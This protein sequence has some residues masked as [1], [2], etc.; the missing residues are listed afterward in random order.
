MKENKTY[1]EKPAPEGHRDEDGH[2][3]VL[4]N[5]HKHLYQCTGRELN[6][7]KILKSEKKISRQVGKAT[8]P[9]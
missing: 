7:L 5:T 9:A 4:I 6:A 2:S 8:P 1:T 3:S